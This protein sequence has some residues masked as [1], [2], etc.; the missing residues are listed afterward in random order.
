MIVDS[1]V[2]LYSPEINR[3]P[4]GWAAAAGESCWAELSTRRRAD[5]RLVQGFPDVGT[6]LRTM[7]AAGVGRA[8]LLGWYWEKHDT[9][10]AQ[11]R[12]F[13]A[14]VR[15]HPDR[16]AAYAAVQP[17]AGAAALSEVRRAR[18]EGLIG[19]GELCPH[20]T[21]LSLDAP[22]FAAV[23]GLAAELELPLNLHVTDPSTPAYPGRVE[24]PLEDFAALARRH[25]R[26]TFVLA[27]WAGGLDVRGLANVCVDTA[28]APLIYRRPAWERLGITARPD[29]VLFGSDYPLNLYPRSQPEP[30]MAGFV[31]EATEAL[32]DPS[33]RAQVMGGNARCLFRL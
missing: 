2:H 5:G 9:C 12:F 22:E 24:T 23:A 17:S 30:E 20:Q 11:N 3:D 27:H 33:V 19:I 26:T 29:Q 15:A 28:A 8:V 16:L 14:C 31:K 7:D 25:P 4:S 1:H 6:L 21:G 32:S 18:D 13:A 10:V